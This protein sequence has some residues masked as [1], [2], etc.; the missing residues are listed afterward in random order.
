MLNEYVNAQARALAQNEAR[1]HLRL[2][3]DKIVYIIL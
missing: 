1:S 2:L 3:F